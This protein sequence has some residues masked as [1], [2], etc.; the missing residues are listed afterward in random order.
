MAIEMPIELI[1]G[2]TKTVYLRWEDGDAPQIRMPI[3][4]ISLAAGAP[5]LS[6]AAHGLTEGW[7]VAVERCQ[8][9][10]QL[11][12]KHSP[13]RAS[14]YTPAHV[15][16][17]GV[18]ELNAISPVDG[19]GREW[20]AYTGGGFILFRTP[21]S[22]TGQTIRVKLKNRIGGTVLMSSEVGD[23]PAN[24]IT[25]VADDAAKLITITFASAA[26]AALAVKSGVWEVEA[27][28]VSGVVTPLVIPSIATIGDEVVT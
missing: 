18:V 28:D 3:S 4:A 11:N 26:T 13:P 27:E 16:D 7:P 6:I 10:R 8:G 17:A 24:T 25:A 2:K 23:A 12:A 15:I 20:P 1:K 9:M 14:D 22:L 21:K 19:S 5:R